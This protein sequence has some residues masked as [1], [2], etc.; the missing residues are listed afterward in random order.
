MHEQTEK[1]VEWNLGFAHDEV[2]AGLEK[3]LAQAAYLYTHATINDTVQFQAT[4]PSGTLRL[5]ARAL[6]ARQSPFSSPIFFHRTLVT[7]TFTGVSTEDEN[8]FMRRLTLTFLRA[9]G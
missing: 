5:I 4:L 9:G 7:M 3:L 1:T 8:A 6:P 2:V